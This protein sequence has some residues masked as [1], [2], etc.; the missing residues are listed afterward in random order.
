MYIV[1]SDLLRRVLFTLKDRFV[2]ANLFDDA[3]QKSKRSLQ[4][5]TT[6]NG[7][8]MT[9]RVYSILEPSVPL[10]QF[11]IIICNVNWLL[12]YASC[13]M[14]RNRF[15]NTTLDIVLTCVADSGMQDQVEMYF[16][17]CGKSLVGNIFQPRCHFFSHDEQ[18]I[19]S[20]FS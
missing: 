11:L 9:C 8:C 13:C 17:S 1:S 6:W 14:Q 15:V 20:Y 18:V 12:Q 19:F 16:S 3:S 4:S 10:S 7:Q 2:L 5:C